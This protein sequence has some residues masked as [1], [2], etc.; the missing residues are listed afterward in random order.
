[1][2]S[3]QADLKSSKNVQMSGSA[4]LKTIRVLWVNFV[5]RLFDI[6]M[7]LVGLLFLMPIFVFIAIRIKQDSP[8][9]VFY[10]GPRMGRNRKPF[11]ILKFRT[12]YE[13]QHSYNGPSV[14]A[15]DDDRGGN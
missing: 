5:K 3:L 12:M 2:S 10:W 4:L 8:G 9:P 7:S 1:M 14:T 6:S 13:D 15:Q 11:K